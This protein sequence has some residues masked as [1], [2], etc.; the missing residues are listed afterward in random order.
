MPLRL[1]KAA[2]P[3]EKA[4]HVEA[5]LEPQPVKAKW[6]DEVAGGNVEVNVLVDAA[7]VE[8]LV[9]L[10]QR[11]FSKL[12]GFQVVILAVEAALPRVEEESVRLTDVDDISRLGGARISRDELY[13]DLSNSSQLSRTYLVMMA[14]S[15][16]VAAIGLARDNVAVVIGAMVI[17][18]LLGPNMA[19]ALATTLADVK[20]ARRALRS[21]AVGIGMA[22]I[23][24]LICGLLCRVDPEV[25][26]ISSR[27]EV[28]MAD[29]ALALASGFAGALAFTTGLSTTVVGVMV[30]VAL[31]PPLTV[32]G[33][34]LGA[35]EGKQ[36]TAALGLFLVNIICVNLAG[37]ATFLFQGIRPAT[38]W[39]EGRARRATRLAMLIWVLVLALLAVVIAWV[40]H[41]IGTGQ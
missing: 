25:G 40:R 28:T 26:E 14:L 34:L 38:W 27:T 3:G 7:E 16:V 15:T 2:I 35:G 24:A 8:H 10:L 18:P 5:L 1:V 9:D 13:E 20:L 12:E 41:V 32:F 33:M 4:S 29:I 39:E 30:S 19:L 6:L 37:V 11:H 17:A 36:A 31:L 21:A 22:L 23:I